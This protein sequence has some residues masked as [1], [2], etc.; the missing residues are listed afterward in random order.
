[1]LFLENLR[2][3]KMKLLRRINLPHFLKKPPYSRFLKERL[4]KETF[5]ICLQTGTIFWPSNKACSRFYQQFFFRKIF[6][7]WE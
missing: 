3:F 5:L 6:H 4:K 2:L 1:M 7:F